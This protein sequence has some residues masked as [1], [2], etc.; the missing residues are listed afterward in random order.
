VSTL[1]YVLLI[2]LLISGLAGSV[3]LAL[4]ITIFQNRAATNSSVG[5][6][7]NSYLFASPLQAKS[8]ANEK[9]RIT[10]FL[11]NDRGLGI[12]NRPVEIITSSSTTKTALQPVTDDTGKALFDISSNTPQSIEVSATS[13]GK[14]LPQKI[15]V[16]FY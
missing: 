15:K 3:F 7:E 1:K 4:R 14:T 6:F 8:S 10:V 9:I 5:S 16:T 2:L 12:P 11:L 13:D